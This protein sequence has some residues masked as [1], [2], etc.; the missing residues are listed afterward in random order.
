MFV[1]KKDII[2][3]EE[4]AIGYVIRDEKIAKGNNYENGMVQIKSEGEKVAKKDSV[5]RYYTTTEQELNQKIEELNLKIQEAL[6]GQTN[7]LPSDIK[8][9]DDQIEDR[10]DGIKTKN[11]LQEIKEYFEE[12]GVKESKI[13]RKFN[14]GSQYWF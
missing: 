7:L 10:I 2:L 13:K 8:A 3:S 11:D 9:I 4:S 14:Y 5:F 12:K 1:I 6:L